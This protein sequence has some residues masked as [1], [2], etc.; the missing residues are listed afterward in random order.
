MVHSVNSQG[1]DT[2]EAEAQELAER[3]GWARG[4]LKGVEKRL[5]A[6]IRHQGFRLLRKGVAAVDRSVRMWKAR[7]KY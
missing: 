6:E 1:S 7:C 3:I 5:A 4:K 2:L